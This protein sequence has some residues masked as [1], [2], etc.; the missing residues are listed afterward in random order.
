MDPFYYYER[1][2]MGQFWG[3]LEPMFGCGPETAQID[4]AW[5][6]RFPYLYR[7]CLGQG[8]YRIPDRDFLLRGIEGGLALTGARNNGVLRVDLAIAHL[9]PLVEDLFCFSVFASRLDA[10]GAVLE[11]VAFC[12]DLQDGTAEAVGRELV[13]AME[14]LERLLRLEGETEE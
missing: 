8:Y 11:A 10:A 12:G 5:R 7:F 1:A 3:G 14:D 4:E 13:Q 6:S 9:W 2:Q